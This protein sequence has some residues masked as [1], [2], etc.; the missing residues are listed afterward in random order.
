MRRV[1]A[2]QKGFTLIELLIVIA[3]IGII[4]SMLIPNLLDAMQKAKQKRTMA[5]MRITGT[6][7]F[8]WL[9]DQ[10]GA[11]AAGQNSSNVV[12]SSYGSVQTV[13]NLE[14]MLVPAYLQNV[15]PIDGWKFP[16]E[17]YL[18][19]TA[20][21]LHERQIMLIR[22]RGRNNSFEAAEYTVTGFD[23]TDYNQDIVWAD[24]FMVRWPQKN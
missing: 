2:G 20:T 18:K 21:G 4:A 5:D 1:T 17:Y 13:A 8:S 9:T 12:L 3:I 14:N 15:P 19:T 16:Y 22:S 24:G 11:A 7:M 23:A 10:V 6:A